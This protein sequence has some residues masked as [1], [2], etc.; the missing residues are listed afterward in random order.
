MADKHCSV[1]IAMSNDKVLN[2]HQA[3]DCLH[4]K[5]IGASNFGATIDPILVGEY[6]GYILYYNL[7]EHACAKPTIKL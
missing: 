2:V 5:L 1:S 3:I 4:C 6:I 7:A